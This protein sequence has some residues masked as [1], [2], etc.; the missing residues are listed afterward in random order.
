MITKSIKLL[1]IA[2]LC[3]WP[4]VALAQLGSV[5]YS[6][7][8]G[9]VIVSAQVN[10]NFSAAFANALNRTGGTM[11]GTLTLSGTAANIILGSNYVSGD[12]DDEG[13]SID[14]SGV[15][16]ISSL[17]VT[18]LTCTGCVGATQLAATAVTAASY[19]GANAI[20]TFTVDADGRLTAASTVA[21]QVPVSTGITGL[22]TGV[23]T[24]LATPSSA[25]LATA[26]T[27][28]TGSGLLVFGTSP[29]L[30]TPNLGTPSAIT[31]T[32]A[33]GLPD[34]ALSSNVALLDNNETVT[35]AWTLTTPNLGTPSAITLT[36]ASGLP[37]SALS[38]NVALLADNETV[39]GAWSFTSATPT[40]FNRRIDVQNAGIINGSFYDSI[41]TRSWAALGDDDIYIVVGGYRAGQWSGV[42]IYGSGS[43][44]ATF[45]SAASSV[46]GTLAWGGGS[47]I[48][49]S[50]NVALLNAANAFSSTSGTLA[51]WTRTGSTGAFLGVA[52]S[53]GS[54]AYWG[55]TSGVFSIQTSGSGYSDKLTIGTSGAATFASTLRV[56]SHV[57]LNAT[58]SAWSTGKAF[59]AATGGAL[60]ADGVNSYVTANYY[61]NAGD[62]FAGTGYAGY[63]SVIGDDGSVRWHLSSASGT[64]GAA[65]TMVESMRLLQTGDVAIRSGAKIRMDGTAGTGDTYTYE[66]AANTVV[67][68]VG[69]VTTFERTAGAVKV[70]GTEGYS[71]ILYLHPDKG[72]DSG[73]QWSLRALD[74]QKMLDFYSASA[75]VVRI[76]G[77]DG[78][79]STNYIDLSSSANGTGVGGNKVFVGIN[80]SGSDAAGSLALGKIGGSYSYVWSDNT[81]VMRIN[82]SAPVEDGGTTSDT[83]GTVV[84]T[85]T[86]TLATKIL[87]GHDISPTDALAT[88]LATPIKSFT[89][90]SGAYNH[91]EFHGIIADWSPAFA[92]DNGRSFN[93]IS[94]FGYTV[95]AFKAQQAQIDDLA[96]RLA[97]L[98]GRR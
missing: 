76:G 96:S 8:S 37:D 63:M 9:T 57:S 89:Y 77:T 84:G 72:D 92:M 94:A 66:S 38:S 34:S 47:A 4:S 73:D 35:G 61:Y 20:P 3:T 49:S 68:V 19:G 67:D 55:V 42:K 43:V 91:T 7:N 2:A 5:P 32:N 98:E 70:L 18:T 39:T 50:S 74:A 83:S 95:Q 58:A 45:A 26:V 12:G 17:S 11:T 1:L 28:E 53:S 16:T 40:I 60:W 29:T 14:S 33:S 87:T 59:E 93:P 6:F 30:T 15:V 41:Y 82:S 79:S 65:A 85:Q 31:L 10:A 86:S 46:T 81:G 78:S 64:A 52:D 80:T 44:A 36:N 51:S 24:W 97:A 22:G 90:K 27:N 75:V 13:I 23:A 62:K 21:P 71:A 88:I 54:F 56:N 25:N 48:S 69:G